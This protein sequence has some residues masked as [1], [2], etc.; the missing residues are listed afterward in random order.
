MAKKI[1]AYCGFD[2]VTRDGYVKWDKDYLELTD[3]QK[4]SL[5]TDV[6]NELIHEHRFLMMTIDNLRNA[7]AGQGLPQ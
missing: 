6:I 3:A 2:P 5:L 7:S 4:L 1:V